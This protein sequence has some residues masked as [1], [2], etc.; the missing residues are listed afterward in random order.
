MSG[1]GK[2]IIGWIIIIAACVIALVISA[3]TA[4]WG[5]QP[6]SDTGFYWMLLTSGIVI[7]GHAIAAGVRK[8]K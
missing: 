5:D 7:S 2:K 1:K 6:L 3:R 4:I 8:K